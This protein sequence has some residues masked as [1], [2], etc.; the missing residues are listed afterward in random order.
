M[1]DT[2]I[3]RLRRRVTF[4]LLA[5]L[6]IAGCSSEQI[7]DVDVQDEIDPSNVQSASG[8]NAVRIGALAR[9]NAATSGTTSGLIGGTEGLFLLGGLLADEYNNGDSFIARQEIDQR[10]VTTANTFLTDAN[11][12]LHRTRLAAEQAIDLLAQYNPS[13]PAWQVGEMYFVQ[14]Y[15]INLLAEH[16]CDGLVFST[17]IDGREEYGV[18]ITTAAAF[19]RALALATDGLAR[20]TGTTAADVRVQNALRLTRGRILLNL[21]RPADAAAAVAAVPSTYEYTILH[22]TSQVNAFWT[23]NNNARRYSVSNNEGG[24]GLNFATANDPRL[25]VCLGNDTACRAIGVT[26]QFATT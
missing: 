11:R 21:N 6:A 12:V 9:L 8:A 16:Y 19:E 22:S 15:V 24:N 26:R 3:A 25:P 13:A 10:T 1:I 14:A 20:V 2:M 17:V 23:Y 7:L 18:P 4:T 5:S